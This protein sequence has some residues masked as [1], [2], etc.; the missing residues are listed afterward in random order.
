MT[1]GTIVTRRDEDAAFVG[2]VTYFP[3]V[4]VTFFG[5]FTEGL[6]DDYAAWA[7]QVA[8]RAVAENTHYLTIADGRQAN[9][10]PASVRKRFAEMSDVMSESGHDRFVAAILV[11]ESALVRGALTA[12][13][14]M[15]RRSL[16]IETVGSI[17]EAIDRARSR[18]A[19][20]GAA[21]P[22]GLDGGYPTPP[23]PNHDR[24]R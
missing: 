19:K 12:I 17:D 23:M 22:A 10:P 1:L 8:A 4:I 11:L 18:L 15:S 9:R 5:T 14:W 6:V 13:Q 7:E 2:D 21:F 16:R 3:V 24:S 20:A